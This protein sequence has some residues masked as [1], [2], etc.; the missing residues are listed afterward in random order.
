MMRAKTELE[1][2]VGVEKWCSKGGEGEGGENN[3]PPGAEEVQELTV[4]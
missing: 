1:A 4:I 3:L 2:C